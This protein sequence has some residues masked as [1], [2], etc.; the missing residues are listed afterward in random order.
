[1]CNK[2]DDINKIHDESS[3]E[4]GRRSLLKMAGATVAAA[5]LLGAMSATKAQA[6]DGPSLGLKPFSVAVKSV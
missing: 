5:P 3:P 2:C 6:A 1:M 4:P